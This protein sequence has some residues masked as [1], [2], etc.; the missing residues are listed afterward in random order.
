MDK[1]KLENS[2]YELKTEKRRKCLKCN[3]K[4]DSISTWNRLCTKCNNDNDDIKTEIP[5]HG[6]KL[7]SDN[8]AST[9]DHHTYYKRRT[10]RKVIEV[11]EDVI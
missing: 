2:P 7:K 10:F 8:F 1:R 9:L 11:K 5:F 6:W 3:K 4:F